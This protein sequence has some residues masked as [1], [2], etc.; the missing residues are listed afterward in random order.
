MWLKLFLKTAW[1]WVLCPAS[2]MSYINPEATTLAQTITSERNVPLVLKSK[3]C[4]CC[5][6]WL[7]IYRSEWTAITQVMKSTMIDL[8]FVTERENGGES[9][10][11]KGKILS[12]PDWM[13]RGGAT[14][15]SVYWSTIG[16]VCFFTGTCVT[17]KGEEVAFFSHCR[18][19]APLQEKVLFTD[20]YFKELRADFLTFEKMRGKVKP[21][22]FF[23]KQI[24]RTSDQ[25]WAL[26]V[27]LN[28]FNNNKRFVCI[29]V[30]L[31]TYFCTIP[32]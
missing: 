19:T 25:S 30:T 1:T 13:Q 28:F 16:C 14:I 29:F 21:R 22:G 9:V 5:C 11:H 31:I 20:F 15:A 27:F 17:W 26:S 6:C 23:Q 4:C 2:I 18:E 12:S 10:F 24:L 7:R 8:L 32:T 3:L